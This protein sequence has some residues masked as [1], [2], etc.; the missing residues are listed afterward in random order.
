MRVLDRV[1]ELPPVV[2]FRLRNMT[3]ID[4][5]GVRALED[6]AAQLRASERTALF[7]GAL[8]QPKAILVSS[9]FPEKFGAGNFCP[10]VDAALER[11]T[12]I[13]SGSPEGM[14]AY[15]A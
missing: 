14:K 2:C 11:A 9:G 6:V 4:A 10:H 8:E 1:D 5:T 12:V 13:N 7:C 15:V 3:A